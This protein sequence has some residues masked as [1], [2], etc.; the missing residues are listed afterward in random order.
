LTLPF[1]IAFLSFWK[2][3]FFAHGLSRENPNSKYSSDFQGKINGDLL[4]ISHLIGREDKKRGRETPNRLLSRHAVP[5]SGCSLAA[6]PGGALS[7][8]A[9]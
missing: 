7:P 8:G 4:E 3:P 9:F 2:K 1:V 6:R 5:N